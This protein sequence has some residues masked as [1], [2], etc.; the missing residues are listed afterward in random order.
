MVFRADPVDSRAWSAV[1]PGNSV[2]FTA[3]LSVA[4]ASEYP[5]IVATMTVKEV[6]AR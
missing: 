4:D 6:I 5:A 2:R 1:Q 3:K